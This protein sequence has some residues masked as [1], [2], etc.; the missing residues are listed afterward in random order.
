MTDSKYKNWTQEQLEYLLNNYGKEDIIKIAKKIDKSVG[1]IYYIFKKE[2]IDL[3]TKWWENTEVEKLKELYPSCSNE[4]LEE[5]LSRSEDAIQ[6]KAVSLGLKKNSFWTED[7][8]ILLKGMA[9]EGISYSKMAQILER[10]KL[11]VYSKLIEQKLTDNCR[12]WTDKELSIIEKMA[13]SGK[14]TYS[15]IAIQIEATPM[16]IMEVCRNNNWQKNIKRT[17]SSGNDKMI[18]LL[19]KIFKGYTIKTEYG[20][21]ERL[22]LDGFVK[23]LKLGFEY[24]GIQHFKHVPR[25]HKTKKEF[26]EAQ[27]RDKRK[28]QLCTEKGIILIRVKYNEE[29]SEE[30]LKEKIR[31]ATTKDLVEKSENKFEEI[32]KIAIN[33]KAKIQNRGFQK[34]IGGYKWPKRK[35]D[36]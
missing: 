29:L 11:S 36:N 20:I 32:K 33:K 3:E 24:D 30:L 4:Q 8:I 19:K 15:D 21:G 22:R 34:P 1:S 27:E 13:I 6:L 17:V 7:E 10:S 5:I 12:R 28:A 18:S 23:Q 9:F 35:I 16:Q 2:E 25:F 31:L 14:Y 26:L